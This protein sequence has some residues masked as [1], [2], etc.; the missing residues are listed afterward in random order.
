M[1]KMA[2][3]MLG[4]TGYKACIFVFVARKCLSLR[5]LLHIGRNGG[6]SAL[7]LVYRLHMLYDLYRQKNFKN[8]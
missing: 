6:L 5:Y 2:I 1:P 3:F 4:K 8:E 7:K